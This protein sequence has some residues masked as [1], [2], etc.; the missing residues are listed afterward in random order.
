MP[1]FESSSFEGVEMMRPLTFLY[2]AKAREYQYMVIPE[3]SFLQIEF[4]NRFVHDQKA[5]FKAKFSIPR[6]TP[7]PSLIV[8]HEMLGVGDIALGYS[9]GAF[10]GDSAGL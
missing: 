8:S 7:G 1:G 9:P 10:R 4:F 5:K 6:S 2:S 3:M